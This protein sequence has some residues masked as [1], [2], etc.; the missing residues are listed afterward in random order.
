MAENSE[1]RDG[2]HAQMCIPHQGAFHARGLFDRFG[3]FDNTLQIAG[4]YKLIMQSLKL[5]APVFLAGIIVADQYAGGKS[6]L[7]K[8]RTLA[9]SEFRKVQ[10][11]L[12]YPLSSAWIWAYAKGL[13]WS[14]ISRFRDVRA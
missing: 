2:M 14:L 13:L 1:V 10:V 11:E 12:G 4:D 5:A 8:H 3:G 9:L 6:A 7:R